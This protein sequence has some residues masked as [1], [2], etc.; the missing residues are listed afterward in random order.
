MVVM[1]GLFGQK[2]LSPTLRLRNIQGFLGDGQEGL[3]S[4]GLEPQLVSS[5]SGSDV[6]STVD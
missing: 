5:R 1:A 3:D 6:C 2:P 4:T